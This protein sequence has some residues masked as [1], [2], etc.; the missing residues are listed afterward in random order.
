MTSRWSRTSLTSLQRRF[1]PV[2]CTRQIYFQFC[3]LATI[4]RGC[5]SVPHVRHSMVREHSCHL[6]LTAISPSLSVTKSKDAP[7][8]F[9]RPNSMPRF[10]GFCIQLL[11]SRIIYI[12][13]NS[14][15]SC[16]FAA[17]LFCC[18]ELTKFISSCASQS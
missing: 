7:R 14:S 13:L 17:K 4:R 18:N 5:L 15:V 12:L 11:F 6:A 10:D 1:H 2:T 16:S 9:Q 8:L 3:F